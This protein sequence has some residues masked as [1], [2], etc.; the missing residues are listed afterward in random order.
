[1]FNKRLISTV[2]GS[3][4]YVIQ[5][6][7]LQWV[8][9]LG[10]IA[11]IIAIG[12]LLQQ[13][14]TGTITLSNILIVAAI[15]IVSL[16]IR[17]I[18]TVQGSKASHKASRAVKLTLRE[19]IFSKLNKLGVSYQEDLSTSEVVQ[20][21][22]EGV[23]QL[24][25]YFGKYL[26]QFFYSL[27]APITLF[28]VLSFVNFTSA[29]VLLLCVPLIP[30]A[31]IAVQKIAKKLLSNYWGQYTKLG[32]DFLENIQGLTTLKIYNADEQK[33]KQMNKNAEKF[34]KITMRVLSMQLNSII[35][36]D[37]IAY[38]AA[39]LGIIISILQFNKGNVGF[40]GCFAIILLASEF[41]IPLRLLGS[42]FHVAMNGIAASEKIFY[43]LDMPEPK[44]GKEIIS[45]SSSNIKLKNI[46]FSYDGKR[47]ILKNISF[48][49]NIGITSIVGES[50]CGKSTIAYLLT[51]RY[52][53]YTGNL[54]IGN[55]QVQNI[56]QSNLLNNVTL[57]THNSYIFKGTVEDTLKLGNTNASHKNMWQALEK[58][59]L[60]EFFKSKDG[61]NTMLSE[62]GSNLSGGQ[63]QRL[64]LARA[65]LKDSPVYVF[66]EV[67]SN[68]DKDSEEDIMSVIYKLGKTKTIIMI[69][70][71]L[72]NVV[73]SDNIYV[74]EKG[75]LVESGNHNNLINKNGKY[76]SLYNEQYKLENI[77]HIDETINLKREAANE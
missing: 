33:N 28:I 34:R 55:I 8:G 37:I 2:K 60:K 41:F 49:A 77:T 27:L 63:K 70:H 6:V 29:L 48:N 24:E 1:M 50:G 16:T 47:E 38:G 53:N 67:T 4:K 71:R 15:A 45:N 69:S 17:Y 74:L 58:V 9:L 10:N 31:I 13:V 25:M 75:V 26:P 65:L 56:K 20:V 35:V 14:L 44:D 32:D 30:L 52:K 42:F 5:N 54:S 21:A 64:A 73:P 11:I 43:I 19:R 39:A 36:M 22:V 46:N 57:V 23:D 51:G 12:I 3:F 7:I 18:A 76:A 62:G 61:L 40:A 66:D 59:N 68:I 72:A